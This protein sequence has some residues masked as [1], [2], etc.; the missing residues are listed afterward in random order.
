MARSLSKLPG[1]VRLSDL[2]TLGVLAE[3]VPA[4]EIQ[5]VLKECDVRS[6]RKRQL[7]VEAT[8]LFVVGMCLYR[9]VSYEE[10]LRWLVEGYRWQKRPAPKIATK[11]A[12]TQ[13]RARL[14]SEVV[15][16][17]FET[18][19][20]PLANPKTQ[21]AWYRAWRTVAID[22][23]SF[24]VPD[25]KENVEAFGYAGDEALAQYPLFRS[26]CLAETGTHAVFAAAMGPYRASEQDLARKV[27]PKLSAG[28]LLLADRNFFGF[29]LWEE[30][31]ATGADLLWRVSSSHSLKKMQDLPDGSYLS[32]ISKGKAH[33]EQIVRVIA[34]K[35]EG[36]DEIDRIVTTILDPEQA[37]AL[38]LAKLYTERWEIESLF[39]E[40]KTHLKGS[41]I[42]MRSKTPDMVEQEFWALLIA[43][44][45]IRSLMHEAALR[46]NLD[47]DKISFTASVSIVRRTLPSRASFS[48]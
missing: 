32:K 27:F 38:E 42:L 35:V 46:Q 34:Y 37:P 21:G 2:V 48:P 6:I 40:M 15:R 31:A 8:M 10:V 25:S 47:P 30:A 41:R 9:D 24:S 19:A 20:V 7:D 43:H 29:E 17:L 12:I 16:R 28:M 5:R 33:K 22:G 3:Y 26:V 1:G 18:L 45:A 44:R 36:S 4:Q 39:D 11:G 23:T 14:G 13:A